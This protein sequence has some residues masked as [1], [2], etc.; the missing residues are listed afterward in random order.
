MYIIYRYDKRNSTE[1]L[2]DV[3]ETRDDLIHYFNKFIELDT[4]LK[5][6]QSIPHN[7]RIAHSIPIL[8]N[9]KY[10]YIISLYNY[11]KEPTMFK[12]EDFDVK[13]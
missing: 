7:P 11:V 10:E 3:V 2:W 8:E 9:N 13:D 4:S 12:F 1:L 5:Y 6:I